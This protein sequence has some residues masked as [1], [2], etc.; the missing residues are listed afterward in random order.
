VCWFVCLCVCMFVCS[1]A[2]RHRSKINQNGAPNR[3]K[4]HQKGTHGAQHGSKIDP[5]AT[6]IDPESHHGLP[7]ASR[8]PHVPTSRSHKG[9]EGVQQGAKGTPQGAKRDPQGPQQAPKSAPWSKMGAKMAPLQKKI[10]LFWGPL[11]ADVRLAYV[12]THPA[13]KALWGPKAP[14][15]RLLAPWVPPWSPFAIFRSPLGPPFSALWAPKASPQAVSKIES[16]FWE[17]FGGP[18]QRRCT[19]YLRKNACRENVIKTTST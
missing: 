19:F 1:L 5:Q 12:R 6:H 10:G 2:T 4:I 7:L 16:G 17:A 15:E 3:S 18:W 11:G 8:G 9:A 13:K 14:P